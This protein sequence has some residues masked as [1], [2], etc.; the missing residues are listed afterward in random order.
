MQC[1]FNSIQACN[2]P[3][4]TWQTPH[5]ILV[6]AQ[7]EWSMTLGK[8]GQYSISGKLT[9]CYFRL[10]D[11]YVLVSRAHVTTWQYFL[12]SG[13]KVRWGDY[14]QYWQWKYKRQNKWGCG[15]ENK[16]VLLAPI[17]W[18]I[19]ERFPIINDW[20]LIR[21]RDVRHAFLLRFSLGLGT[22]AT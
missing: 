6:Y 11:T 9:K 3:F 19:P 22:L 20:Y 12:N 2:S 18:W 17:L 21:F 5:K 8:P 14:M 13:A 15:K 1:E 4:C 7:P 10:A 16:A